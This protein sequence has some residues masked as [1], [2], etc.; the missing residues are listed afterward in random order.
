MKP[1]LQR[2]TPSTARVATAAAV[3]VLLTQS[4]ILALTTL[5][6]FNPQPIIDLA[7]RLNW[8]AL[9]ISAVFFLRHPLPT[10]LLALSLL[11]TTAIFFF[12]ASTPHS[13]LWFLGQNG[14]PLAF[15]LLTLAALVRTTSPRSPAP[16]TPDRS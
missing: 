7:V 10:I 16:Q 11:T 13:I 4:A 3:L 8:L 14:L 1:L 15:L 2:L 6:S 12:T 9:A 5:A